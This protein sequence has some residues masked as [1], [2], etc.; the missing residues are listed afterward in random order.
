MSAMSLDSRTEMDYIR[1]PVEIAERVWWVG[2]I[3]ADDPLQ[4]HVT[5]SSRVNNQ[6]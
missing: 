4:C 2:H 1:N 6:C 3:Q 5:G